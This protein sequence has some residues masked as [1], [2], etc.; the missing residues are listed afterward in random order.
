[1]YGTNTGSLSIKLSVVQ[2]IY[3]L[4]AAFGDQGDN[5][6]LGQVPFVVTAPQ[7]QVCASNILYMLCKSMM[8]KD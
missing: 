7:S 3:Y 8:S 2:N 1:M 5:W 6:Y 4:W